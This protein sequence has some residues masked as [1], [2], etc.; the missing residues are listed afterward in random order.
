MVAVVLTGPP[1]AG[2]TAVLT[3]LSDALSDDD[4]AHATVEVEALVWTHPPLG[5]HEHARL[6]GHHFQVLRDLGYHLLLIAQTLET[7]GDVAEL[8]D[9]VGADDAVI[10]RLEAQPSASPSVSPR[11]GR[12]CPVSSNTRGSS[13]RACHVS[14]ACTSSSPRTASPPRTSLRGSERMSRPWTAD[15]AMRDSRHDHGGR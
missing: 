6:V 13:P 7:D 4:I 3:A 5:D 1:G 14:P 15:V 2:K 12:A 9:A 10:V 11:V 8:V